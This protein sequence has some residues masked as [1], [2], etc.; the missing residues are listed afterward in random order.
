M[1]NNNK[2]IINDNMSDEEKDKAFK[3]WL[4]VEQHNDKVNAI[5]FRSDLA[6]SCVIG[7][8]AG[9]ISYFGFDATLIQACAMTIGTLIFIMCF[10]NDS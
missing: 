8:V 7:I 10:R 9:L 3:E 6:F 1:I 5:M 4:E 2:L